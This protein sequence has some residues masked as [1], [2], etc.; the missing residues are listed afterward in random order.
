MS[1]LP[2]FIPPDYLNCRF[3]NNTFPHEVDCFLPQNFGGPLSIVRFSGPQSWHF[4]DT[5]RL[6]IARNVILERIIDAADEARVLNCLLARIS[7]CFISS[8]DIMFPGS[9]LVHSA[10]IDLSMLMKLIASAMSLRDLWWILSM[11][12][13]NSHFTR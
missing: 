1:P 6:T 9:G 7:A 4:F 11:Q 12:G 13:I 5:V 3:Q 2:F 8:F 10:S